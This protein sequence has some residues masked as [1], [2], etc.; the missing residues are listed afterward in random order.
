MLFDTQIFGASIACFV[1]VARD[2]SVGD[3][4]SEVNKMRGRAALETTALFY[5]GT[6]WAENKD[7]SI[8][9]VWSN[10]LLKP[11]MLRLSELFLSNYFCS[12]T[13]V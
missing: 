7:P 10:S 8:N 6:F 4:K 9:A 13:W 1:L 11:R 5:S 2:Q 3:G 12:F